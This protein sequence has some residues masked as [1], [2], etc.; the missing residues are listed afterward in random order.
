MI[1]AGKLHKQ[2]EALEAAGAI[3][4]L[5]VD[6]DICLIYNYHIINKEVNQM[7]CSICGISDLDVLVEGA[8]PC[9][10]YCD[11]IE[12]LGYDAGDG[13]WMDAEALASAGWGNDE[14]YE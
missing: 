13:M 1:A 12:Y 10:E 9:G 11:I 8:E 2:P 4:H 3:F 7:E 14:D 5:G 6:K